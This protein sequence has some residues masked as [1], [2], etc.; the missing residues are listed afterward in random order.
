MGN[1]VFNGLGKGIGTTIF[2]SILLFS[3][4]TVS[5]AAVVSKKV[6]TDP[7]I[8]I[9]NNNVPVSGNI[10]PILIDGTTY[11]PVRSLSGALN[12]NV[13]WDGPKKS[14]YI[15][16][17]VNPN[18]VNLK[19]EISNLENFVRIKDLRITELE[20]AAKSKD[21]KITELE[22]AAKTKDAKITELENAIKSKDVKIAELEKQLK[23]QS[24]ISL[25]DLEKQLNK[26]YKNWNSLAFDITLRGNKDYI[27]VEIEIDLGV[28]NY[29]KEWYNLQD[30][31]IERFLNNIASDIWYEYKDA[32]ITGEVINSKDD[33]SLVIFSGDKGY[34]NKVRIYK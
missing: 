16:D 4:M 10:S 7:K 6:D 19:N 12:K 26:D 20:N 9:L 23:A 33:K 32:E 8:N 11:L 5:E 24:T 22:N 2:A 14:I 25:K 27:D 29:N 30:T 34:L 15:T 31:K 17:N 13:L 18:E 1:K 28:V 3:Q 21:S